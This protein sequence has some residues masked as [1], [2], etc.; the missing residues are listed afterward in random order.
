MSSQ[1]YDTIIR[2][3]A[4]RTSFQKDWE[5][6]RDTAREFLIRFEQGFDTQLLADEV[7]MGKTYVAMSVIAARLL[8]ASRANARALL[9]TPS[10]AV[11]RA[12]WEQEL[13]SFSAFYVNGQDR[14]RKRTLRPLVVHSYW[15]LIACLHAYKNTT[16]SRIWPETTCCILQSIYEWARQNRY[17]S[18]RSAFVRL[19]GFDE[20][21]KKALEFASEY[22][23]TGWFSYLDELKATQ[24]QAMRA[25]LVALCTDDSQGACNW[26]KDAF[27]AFAAKQER[28]LPNVLILGM[29][30][31]DR[32]RTDQTETRRFSTFVLGVLVTGLHEH[33][34][35]A[36]LSSLR[37][38]NILL[39][40]VTT[41]SLKELAS[42]DL[43]RTRDCVI[44][45]RDDDPDLKE[46]WW[47][48]RDGAD[49]NSIRS[50]FKDLMNAVV[51]QKLRESGIE[52]AVVDEVHNWKGGKHGAKAFS[53]TFSP[54]IPNKLLLSAT[55]FQLEERE[56][57]TVFDFATDRNGATYGVLDA[58]YRPNGEVANCLG[59]NKTFQK[60]WDALAG[61]DESVARLN[62]LCEGTNPA[63]IEPMLVE[64]IA[65]PGTRPALRAFSEAA[66]AYRKAVDRLAALQRQIVIRHLKPRGHRSFHA[67]QDFGTGPAVQRTMLY[68]VEG[69]SRDSDAFIH[70]L[71]MRLDQQT[72]AADGKRDVANARLMSGL[73]SSVRAF[74]SSAAVAAQQKRVVGAETAKYMAM[75]RR[76]LGM[77]EHPKVSATVDRALSN[78]QN[79]RKTLIFCERV[80]TLNEIGA[81]LQSRINPTET[82]E[83]DLRAKRK[84]LLEEAAF[85]DLPLARIFA[86]ASQL[87]VNEMESRLTEWRPKAV[88]FALDCLA[89]CRVSVTERRVFRL[90]DLWL[91]VEFGYT[92][93][94]RKPAMRLFKRLRE[95]AMQDGQDQRW[96][97]TSFLAAEGASAESAETVEE[98]VNRHA[99]TF[100]E[101]PLNLWDG[102]DTASFATNLWG[103]IESE[104]S[105][106]V[107]DADTEA[108][109]RLVAPGFFDTVLDIQKGL[110]KVLLRPD[111]FRTYMGPLLANSSDDPR[112][113]EIVRA[114]HSGMRAPRGTG[115]SMWRRMVRFLLNLREANG[116]MNTDDHTNT[117]RRSLWRG[118][119]LQRSRAGARH[120]DEVSNDANADDDYAV[121][122]LDGSVKHDSRIVLCAAFNSPLAPD[123]LICTSIG[124]EGIDLHRECAEIIHHDLPWNPARLEQRIGRVDRV[125]SLAEASRTD[126]PGTGLV[127]VGIPFQQLSYERFQYSVLLARAQRFEV[128]LGKPDFA[129]DALDEEELNEKEQGGVLETVTDRDLT[130]ETP[131]PCLPE[132]LARWF[133]VDLSLQVGSA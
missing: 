51:R 13:R 54:S 56:M 118:V 109:A 110:R 124:S 65:D 17:L 8:G 50:F 92:L 84:N 2:A 123:I 28:Y 4:E 90:L 14:A 94:V 113:A 9:I 52:L 131:P 36:L 67:G 38:A 83:L 5:R 33:T 30:S 43:Y 76:A 61:D 69:M 87:E 34:R 116:S 107:D 24:D 7:G 60:A 59:A 21:S 82:T 55:P 66:V 39:P 22:S 72:R 78:Y 32:P 35:E 58:I 98:L 47:S 79:G 12:K 16:I 96:L 73:T 53:K 27:K 46:R 15:E 49:D 77:S 74:E 129:V 93:R 95:M 81:M 31:L 115:E 75:F 105:L 120:D 111:L 1:R 117:R 104:A 114:V 19:E 70:F 40:K 44:R 25:H 68:D 57:R 99:G 85:V 89:R 106:L 132:E 41:E 108:N 64:L 101:R 80:E 121:R 45:A 130:L 103:L 102:D 42:S 112:M 97:R 91:L 133:R 29:S 122:S 37:K 20:S 6:Q 119:N 128:L 126:Q 125:G 11:L 71:A 18:R 62:A 88:A 3:E 23:Q 86:Q 63:A 26:F 127:Q 10:S 100:F 48:L